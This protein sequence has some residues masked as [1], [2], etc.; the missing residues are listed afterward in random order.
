MLS[1]EIGGRLVDAQLSM[2]QSIADQLSEQLP[3]SQRQAFIDQFIKEAKQGIEQNK[4]DLVA[5][6]ANTMMFTDSFKS[7]F[8]LIS[9]LTVSFLL[10]IPSLIGEILAGI[11]LLLLPKEAIEGSQK[12][13]A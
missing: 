3:E 2:V 4:N 12:E 9:A 13:T 1:N 6:M 7:W 5:G 8:P 10:F 11:T